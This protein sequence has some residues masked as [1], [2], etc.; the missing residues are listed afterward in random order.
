MSPTARPRFWIC[1]VAGLAALWITFRVLDADA[2]PR[3]LEVL[4]SPEELPDPALD[5]M[6]ERF[7]AAARQSRRAP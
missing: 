7:A 3:A 1:A 4:D 5:A 2:A 6:I